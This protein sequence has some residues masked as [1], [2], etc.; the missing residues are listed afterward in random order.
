VSVFRSDSN[1]KF[2]PIA[3]YNFTGTTAKDVKVAD[4][5]GDDAGEIIVNADKLYTINLVTNHL[6][7]SVFTTQNTGFWSFVD[8]ADVDG[9][10]G[11]TPD[12]IVANDNATVKIFLGNRVGSEVTYNTAPQIYQGTSSPRGLIVKNI[13]NNNTGVNFPDI[14]IGDAFAGLDIKLNVKEG[15]GASTSVVRQTFEYD[16][17]FGQLIESVDEQGRIT[18][19]DINPMNGDVNSITKR[20][21][22]RTPDSVTTFDYSGNRW[23][24]VSKFTDAEGKVTENA[25][26]GK[27]R[28]TQVKTGGIPISTLTY[29]DDAGNIATKTDG[30]GKITQYSYQSNTNR[31][32]KET[33]DDG[34]GFTAYSYDPKGLLTSV[35]NSDG[36]GQKFEN[37]DNLGRAQTIT[38]LTVKGEIVQKY[39]YR[40]TGEISKATN[41]DNEEVEYF[42]DPRNRLIRTKNIDGSEIRYEYDSLSNLTQ[43]T[44][45]EGYETDYIYDSVANDSRTRLLETRQEI[46]DGRYLVTKYEYNAALQLTK[47]TDGTGKSTI[48]EYDGLGRQIKVTQQLDTALD[49]GATEIINSTEY[50]NNGNIKSVTDGNGHT[51]TYTYDAR[52]LK[53]TSTDAKGNITTY[54]YDNAGNMTSMMTS[55]PTTPG[56]ASITYGYDALNRRNKIIDAIGGETTTTYYLSGDTKTVTNARGYTS[57]YN[58]TPSTRTLTTIDAEGNQTETLYDT[59]GRVKKFTQLGNLSLPSDDRITNYNYDLTTNTTTVYRPESITEI[60]KLDSVGNTSSITTKVNGIYQITRAEHDGLKHT[61]KTIDAENNTNEYYYDNLGNLTLTYQTDATTGIFHTTQTLFNNIGW[62]TSTINAQ[63]QLFKTTYDAVGNIITSTENNLRTTTNTYD[64][65]NRKTQ[66]TTTSGADTLNTYIE[67]DAVGNTLKPP[68][69]KTTAPDTTTTH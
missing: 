22:S 66:T 64:Q 53:S 69:P 45:A 32:A 3:D 40:R 67:Y 1:G 20:G 57:Q 36:Y 7:T 13:N 12:I 4:L 33:Y 62:K 23:G 42:Y 50:F 68:M 5:N 31:I 61:T 44:D 41:A 18:D 34:L 46:K 27:G 11:N 39:E 49:N 38:Q 63:G 54:G 30:N 56:T 58:Y 65:I 21:D 60:T 37:Y 28:L 48:Y 16:P 8:V 35:I 19:Y 17:N 59:L 29:S 9:D 55:N 51:T 25:Y 14:I 26:D 2:S 43:V 24:L 52:N 47:T 10:P 15:S 6:E